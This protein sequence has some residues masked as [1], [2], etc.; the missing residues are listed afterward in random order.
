MNKQTINIHRMSAPRQSTINKV[1]VALTEL[2]EKVAPEKPTKDLREIFVTFCKRYHINQ[3]LWYSLKELG[4]V[5]KD[6]SNWSLKIKRQEINKTMATTIIDS[7]NKRAKYYSDKAAQKEQSKPIQPIVE[8]KI[9]EKVEEK[10]EMFILIKQEDMLKYAD[11]VFVSVND[12]K[13]HKV[14]GSYHVVKVI[15]KLN[16]IPTAHLK[17]D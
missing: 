12:I 8:Q 17:L 4:Y 5:S 3:N 1:C 7:Y 14:E 13:N 9:E 11:H 10:K 6:K 15:G 2:T 16:V